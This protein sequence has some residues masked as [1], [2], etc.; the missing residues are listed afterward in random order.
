M[1]I[2]RLGAAARRSAARLL[3]CASALMLS[4]PLSP[5][6]AVADTRE[7]ALINSGAGLAPAQWGVVLAAGHHDKS[8]Y[9]FATQDIAQR[10]RQVGVSNIRLLTSAPANVNETTGAALTTH[11]EIRA[12][13][14]IIA[15]QGPGACLFFITS[16]A[17]RQGIFLALDTSQHYLTASQLDR[18]V[19]EACQDRPQVLILSGCHSGA[20]ITST[21]TR[22]PKRIVLASASPSTVSYG[23]T[24]TERH[25][26]FE[27]CL[28]KAYDAGAATW[29][30]MFHNALPCVEEREDWLRVPASKPHAFF[31]PAV[32]NLRIPGR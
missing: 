14:A 26:N 23:A 11:D 6:T 28:I 8:N 5:P 24:T 25:L 9:D 4:S 3:Y 22:H 32:A 1:G 19:T 15:G 20:M 31:G 16:H 17:N 13:F 27:R 10:L 29:R 2:A 7:V 12:A 18:Y 21:M 30:D